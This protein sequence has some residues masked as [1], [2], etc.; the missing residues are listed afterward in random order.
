MT[1]ALA[2]YS[3]LLAR[4]LLALSSC[5]PSSPRAALVSCDV[6]S[7]ARA[8]VRYA[9]TSEAVTAAMWSARARD[10]ANWER[11]TSNEAWAA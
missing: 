5:A 8:S 3:I 4:S 2:S 10:W 9:A 7:S 6:R 11:A 1:L